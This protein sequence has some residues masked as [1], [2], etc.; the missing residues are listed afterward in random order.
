MLVCII[1]KRAKH[2]PALFGIILYMHSEHEIYDVSFSLGAACACSIVLRRAGLQFAS[3]PLDWIAGGTLVD[4]ATLVA[5]RFDGWFEEKDF[6][7]KGTNPVNGLGMFDNTYTHFTHLH[8]FDDGPIEKS[9]RRVRDKYRRRESRLFSM[10]D[11]AR[12][13][14]CVYINRPSMK[15]SADDELCTARAMIAKTFPAA[16]VDLVYFAHDAGRPSSERIV[17]EPEPGVFRIAFDYADPVRD[18]DM[19]T[20]AAVLSA[21]G[22]RARDFRTAKEKRAYELRKKMKKYGVN[23]YAGLVWAQTKVQL[24]RTFGLKAKTNGMDIMKA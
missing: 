21:E 24:L 9:Y 15:P 1:P 12:R 8:D 17:S 5:S 22:F 18:V 16:A 20:A 23:S 2:Y 19:R 11:T 6:V 14:L 3:F 10:C 13:I 4:R 7:Y